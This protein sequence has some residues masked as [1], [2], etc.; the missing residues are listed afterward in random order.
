MGGSKGWRD[1]AAVRTAAR[2]ALPPAILAYV[3]SGAERERT[4]AANQAAFDR[5]GLY[6]SIADNA[7]EPAL[8]R[9]VLGHD[10]AIP[11]IFGPAGMLGLIGSGGEIAATKACADAG[12]LFMLSTAASHSIEAVAR[13]GQGPRLFQISLPRDRALATRLLDR[14]KA[15]GYDGLCVTVD[16]PVHGHRAAERRHGLRIPPPPWLI[17]RMAL[18]RPRW[19]WRMARS[20]PGFA[21]FADA[22]LSMA[23]IVDQIVAP[24][25]WDDLGWV[26][27][28]WNGRLAAKGLMRPDDVGRA[29]ALGYEAVFLSNQGGRHF[30]CGISPLDILPEALAEARAR[31]EIIVDG[32]IRSGVDIVKAIALG[33]TACSTVRPFCYGLAAAGEEGIGHVFALFRSEMLRTLRFMGCRSLDDLGPD[34]L[35]RLP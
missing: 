18:S 30:D 13:C 24:I 7:A 25:V 29:A 34:R 4:L 19:A 14:A 26:R 35:R 32:G 10:L 15:A 3:D 6:P 9:R 23:D 12:S 8:R 27:D 31:L 20:R 22:G 16:N 5:W 21:N 1:I 17:A 28:R 33:A 11:L 2:R